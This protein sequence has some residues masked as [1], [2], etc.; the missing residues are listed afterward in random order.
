MRILLGKSKLVFPRIYF[1]KYQIK[2]LYVYSFQRIG[3]TLIPDLFSFY[4]LI[5]VFSFFFIIFLTQ[6]KLSTPGINGRL[7]YRLKTCSD[8]NFFYIFTQHSALKNLFRNVS[9]FTHS[10]KVHAVMIIY[11]ICQV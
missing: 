6:L 9:D 10:N 4:L 1:C 5:F 8:K 2:T 7:C 11:R 3:S